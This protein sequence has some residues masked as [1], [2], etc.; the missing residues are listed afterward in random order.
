VE[1]TEKENPMTVTIRE[2]SSDD[3]GVLYDVCLRTGSAG[4]DASDLYGDPTLLGCIYVGPY[5]VLQEG[6]GFVPVD[7][8]GV[9][10]YVLAAPDTRAFEAACEARWWPDLRVT[11]PDAP[12]TPSTPDDEL[13]ALIHRPRTAPE[14][15]VER[16]RA[17]VHIDLYPRMQGIGVGRRLMERML[18]WLAAHGVAGVHLGVDPANHRAIGFYERLGFTPLMTD[19]DV[20]YLGL[21]LSK[22]V[23]RVD[24]DR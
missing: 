5:V 7:D 13:R 22:R 17:H 3:L 19:D 16:H 4:A 15:V 23:R 12:P 20:C 14:A 11:H 24:V 8:E 9:G 1:K 10:G 6:I 18:T 2:A 21:Q